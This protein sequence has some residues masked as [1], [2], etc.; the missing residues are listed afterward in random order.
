MSH[1]A[2]PASR[3]SRIQ[4]KRQS[5]C[6]ACLPAKAIYTGLM[7]IMCQ[8]AAINTHRGTDTVNGGT[9]RCFVVIAILAVAQDAVVVLW[10]LPVTATEKFNRAETEANPVTAEQMI[11]CHSTYRTKHT[12]NGKL[13]LKTVGARKPRTRP[14]SSRFS[15]N[16]SLIYPHP[17]SFHRL[18]HGRCPSKL[19][20]IISFVI[21]N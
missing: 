14:L 10:A 11:C 13:L 8:P 6:F 15:Y 17:R 2:F 9:S 21:R 4:H 5:L 20:A 16:N 7:L 3:R 19:Q 1:Q 12:N 18:S